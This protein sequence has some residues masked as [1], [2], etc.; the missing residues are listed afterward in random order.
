MWQEL[1]DTFASQ[2]QKRKRI[3]QLQNQRELDFNVTEITRSETLNLL[4]NVSVSCMALGPGQVMW[5]PRRG[6]AVVDPVRAAKSAT[7]QKTIVFVPPVR[8]ELVRQWS[9]DGPLTGM[10]ALA[11]QVFVLRSM[12]VQ[13]QTLDGTF[14]REWGSHGI[15]PGQ[16]NHPEG[17]A[18]HGA[19]VIVCDTWNYRLQVFK[20]D[21]TFLRQWGEQ[22]KGR[23]MFLRP[24]GVVVHGSE[25]FVS[26][27]LN[28]LVQVF[29]LSGSFLRQWGQK[30]RRR[31]G[32]AWPGN[33]AIR[34]EEIFLCDLWTFTIQVF[35]FDGTF[36][37]QWGSYGNGPAQFNH[38]YTLALR[39]DQAIVAN[40]GK[41]QLQVFGL[42]GAFLETLG[43]LP[44]ES[45]DQIYNSRYMCVLGEEIFVGGSHGVLVFV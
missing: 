20:L 4:P 35:G 8:G 15:G 6:D 19:E 7:F 27:S 45:T 26:D 14:I 22:G 5:V 28:N 24:D 13:V 37:R 3:V 30:G 12:G 29:T 40:F 34:G 43:D 38:P 33:I 25:V 21:G 39:G 31:R 17:L 18:V 42:D 36:L 10:V 32:G 1:I 2:N 9:T 41:H 11:G 44:S 23:G 16:F